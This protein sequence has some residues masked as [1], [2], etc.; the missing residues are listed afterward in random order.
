MKQIVFVE[1]MIVKIVTWM[2]IATR[3]V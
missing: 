3:L 2:K 1:S